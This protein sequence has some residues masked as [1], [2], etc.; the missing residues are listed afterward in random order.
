MRLT[1]GAKADRDYDVADDVFEDQVP[2]DDP[3]ENLA[4][5]GV[6]IGV[7][8]AGDGNHR[9]QFGVTES[10]KAA[11]HGD[12]EKRNGD[13][14][15]SRRASMHENLGGTAATQEVHENVENLGVENGR[16][17]KIFARGCGSGKHENTGAD[18]RANTKSGQ[19]PGA[20]RFLQ[21]LAG[22]FG[23]RDQFVDRLAAEKLVVGSANRCGGFRG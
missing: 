10:G 3:G 8:A 12:Q 13:G 9:G 7:G 21:A 22:G 5:R 4:E 18:D 19:R 17:L 1:V 2:A 23:F 14:G 15:A 16:R 6:G 11:S 20:Q